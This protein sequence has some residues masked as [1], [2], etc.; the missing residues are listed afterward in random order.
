MRCERTVLHPHPPPSNS[1]TYN[2][3]QAKDTDLLAALRKNAALAEELSAARQMAA[4]A[5]AAKQAAAATPPAAPAADGWGTG[6]DEAWE[7]AGSVGFGRRGSL[8]GSSAAGG[9]GPGGLLSPR[10]P[11]RPP[12]RGGSLGLPGSSQLLGSAA[13]SEP[14]AHPHACVTRALAAGRPDRH[15]QQAARGSSEPW[16]RCAP[17][18]PTGTTLKAPH[19]PSALASSTQSLNSDILESIFAGGAPPSDANGPSS[20]GAALAAAGASAD[21]DDGSDAALAR[22]AGAGGGYA[23]YPGGSYPGGSYT[24]AGDQH[25]AALIA[26][27]AQQAARSGALEAAERRVRQ[28]E[29]EVAD[30]EAEVGGV[31]GGFQLPTF[32]Q[33][34]L[35]SSL[36]LC[37]PGMWCCRGHMETLP[38]SKPTNLPLL[39]T[40]P[41]VKLHESAGQLFQTQ[42]D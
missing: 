22:A 39:F 12:L 35:H 29:R 36:R 18:T 4:A 13:P 38:T 17:P 27:A 23:S 40:T 33:Q 9:G 7:D 3:P 28:L 15:P 8:G 2:T 30:L 19:T 16:A 34:A 42:H 41:Q 21:G 26:V 37:W 32:K 11:G 25:S 24:G 20:S 1:H 14:G 5:A 10:A 6:G 31:P